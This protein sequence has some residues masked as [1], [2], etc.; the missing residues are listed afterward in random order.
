MREVRQ[1]V[2][3]QPGILERMDASFSRTAEEA[4]VKMNA[5]HFKHFP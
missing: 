3:T 1:K 5:N 2:P 4:C